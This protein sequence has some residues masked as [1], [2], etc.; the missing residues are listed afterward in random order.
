M[1]AS[2]NDALRTLV[3]STVLGF[4]AGAL[5][6]MGAA[7]SVAMMGIALGASSGIAL[8]AV[9]WRGPPTAPLAF[10]GLPVVVFAALGGLVASLT[11]ELPGRALVPLLLI[12]IAVR[13]VPRSDTRLWRQAVLTAAAALIP[14]AL[15]LTLALWTAAGA[16]AA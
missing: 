15:A 11:G 5:G 12:P 9:L 14:A 10:L 3:A 7:A 4:A 8:L 2:T 13:L 16:A 1:L 6:L